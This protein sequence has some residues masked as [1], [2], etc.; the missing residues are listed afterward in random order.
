[1]CCCPEFYAFIYTSTLGGAV[2]V[3]QE[4]EALRGSGTFTSPQSSVTHDRKESSLCLSVHRASVPSC[5]SINMES[6]LICFLSLSWRGGRA[7]LW[8]PRHWSYQEAGG[9]RGLLSHFVWLT[10]PLL[11]EEEG[12]GKKERRG[13]RGERR[14]KDSWRETRMPFGGFWWA[15]R[16]QNQYFLLLASLAVQSVGNEMFCFFVNVLLS[17]FLFVYLFINYP[18]PQRIWGGLPQKQKP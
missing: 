9:S 14:E 6:D 4:L 7:V 5:N 17:R 16:N 2:S 1:M 8:G 15:L 12:F 3:S 11:R 10:Y 18:N 13:R